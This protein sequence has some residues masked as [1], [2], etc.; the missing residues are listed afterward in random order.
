MATKDLSRSLGEGGSCIMHTVGPRK[1]MQR[2]ERTARRAYLRKVMA[3][4][5]FVEVEEAPEREH[6]TGSCPVCRPAAIIR[7]LEKRVGQRWDDVFAEL[8]R[9]FDRRTRRGHHLVDH[10][11]LG[12]REYLGM[13]L[14]VPEQVIEWLPVSFAHAVKFVITTDGRLEDRRA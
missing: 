14:V 2:A 10:H 6:D 5:G 3:D 8:V 7:W 12:H 1:R 11:V 9:Q 13:G 4:P